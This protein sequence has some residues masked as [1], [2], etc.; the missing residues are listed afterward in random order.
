MK[1]LKQLLI[2]VLLFSTCT[3]FA[4]QRVALHSNG[5][6][7]I[8]S[9]ANPFTDAYNAAANG[10][11]LYLPGGVIPFPATIDKGLVI[12]GAGHYPDSTTATGK[13]VLSGSLTIRG[14]ADKLWL[15]GIELTGNINFYNNHKVDSV[16]IRRCKFTSLEYTGN[17]TTPCVDNVIRE[18]VINGGVN[19][20]NATSSILSNNIISGQISY[21]NNI[22]I[23]NNILFHDPSSTYYSA[24]FL[25][26]NTCLI[27]NNIIL[28]NN[29]GGS[30]IYQE[31][32]LNSFI[33]NIFRVVP[34]TGT[35]T[36]T[37]NYNSVDIATVF[38][39]QSGNVFDYTQDYHLVNPATYLGTDGSQVG[40]YG[41]M[42]PI[43]DGAVPQNP[44]I[45][46]KNMAP[47]TDVNGDLQIQIQVE[48]QDY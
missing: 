7:T 47:T 35:N 44:H 36:F 42:Y 46:L 4:Q 22:G 31:C 9:G 14:E 33:N 1:N 39:N 37:T 30:N 18:N 27:S 17:G 32:N 5:A 48:A 6:T 45:Q 2:I 21:A 40:I 25:Y 38:V 29:G 24:L 19:F 34:N 11:T 3:L 23:S 28:R 16:T 13:T 20:G 12:I 26:S 43:K 15:E 8:F 10:D 41:G